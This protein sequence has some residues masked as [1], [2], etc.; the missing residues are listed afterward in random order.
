MKPIFKAV[1]EPVESSSGELAASL[2]LP[3]HN[4][5]MPRLV[6][7]RREWIALPE[8]GVSP[9]NAK[10]DSGARSSSIHAENVVLSE[11]EKTVRFTT[12]NHYNEVVF[13]ESPVARTARVKSSSG[14]A[15]KR[16]FIETTAVVAGGFSWKILVS[17]ANRSE[18]LCPMLLGR[19]ALSGYFLIDPQGAHLLGMRRSLN[20][21]RA[22]PPNADQS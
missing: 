21:F 10:T 22:K 18:M 9:L 16:I 1:S 2:G 6:I 8:L 14:K 12:T 5:G 19:R 13:C 3:T 20:E 11:D 15:K 17:L 7:G 4:A